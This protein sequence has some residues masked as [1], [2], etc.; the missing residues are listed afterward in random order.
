MKTGVCLIMLGVLGLVAISAAAV[1][2]R[3]KKFTT[4]TKGQPFAQGCFDAN[5]NGKPATI[6]RLGRH[7][8][9]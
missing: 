9:D 5:V 1:S 7:G 3:P 4:D 6:C 8:N 2:T